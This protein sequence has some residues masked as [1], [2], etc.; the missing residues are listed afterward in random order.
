MKR[1]SLESPHQ[2]ESNGGNFMSLGVIDIEI[3][4]EMIT[5]RHFDIYDSAPFFRFVKYLATYRT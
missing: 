4:N 3:F 2:D 5:I 1:S